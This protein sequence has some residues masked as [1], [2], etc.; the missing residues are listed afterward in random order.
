MKEDIINQ[1][2]SACPMISEAQILTRLEK[3]KQKTGG[4]ISD[5]TLL[6]MIAAEFGCEV[7]CDK[8]EMPPLMIKDLVPGLSDVTVIGRVLAI[9]PP[10]DFATARKGKLASLLIA[11]RS[12]LLRIVL[13]NDK[14]TLVENGK[15]NVGQVTRFS[16]GYTREDPSGKV[17]L[18]LGEKSEVETNP[19]NVKEREYPNVCKFSTKIN[20]LTPNLRNK[21]INIAGTIKKVFPPSI[22]NR[23]NSTQGKVMRFVLKDRT[24]EIPVVIWNEK[25]DE[26][27]KNLKVGDKLQV[28]NGKLK[29]ALMEG[30]EIN[31]DASTYV[32][33][34]TEAEEIDNIA[35]L[36]EGMEQVNVEG[37][38][39]TKPVLRDVRTAKEEQLKVAT[40]EIKDDT[41][42][43]WVSAWRR[44]AE[45]AE[46]LKPG[47]RILVKSAYVK[48]GFADQLEITTRNT[49]SIVIK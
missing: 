3:E 33:P 12:S 18:N 15:V 36:S 37:E 35:D 38:V 10:K 26:L 6:R 39:T 13:W 14:T 46:K 47:D 22:F 8:V 11:D 32:G 16:H 21:R 48:Y 24:G 29:K 9:F 49:T 45:A 2:T 34:L 5:E 31:V 7:A 1:I 27:E 25:V 17:E 19:A 23:E 28:V 4:F 40:F 44:Q 41:G 42:R 30:F 43:I 20:D